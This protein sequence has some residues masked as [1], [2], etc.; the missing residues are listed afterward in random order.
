MQRRKVVIIGGGA[1]GFF[2]AINAAQ[3]NREL[4]VLILEKTHKVLSKVKVSGGGRCNVTH[5]LFEIPEMSRR[6]PRGLQFVKK[7]FHQFFTSDCIRWFEERGVRLKTEADGR[8]FPVTDS[9]QTIIDCF[10]QEVNRHG[11]QLRLNADVKTI[12]KTG[13]QFQLQLSNGEMLSADAVCIAC[14]GYPKAAAFEWLQQLGHTIEPPVPSLFTFNLP[15]HPI[16]DL[17]GVSVEQARVKIENSKLAEEGPVLITHWG[18]SGPA[19]LKL[20]A[21]GAQELAEKQYVFNVHINWIPAHTELSLKDAF[22]SARTQQASRK[23]ANTN[24][25]SLPNRLWLFLLDQSGI[26]PDLRFS[27][28]PAKSENQLIRNLIDYKVSVQGKTTFKEEFVT[29]GGIHLSE[30]DPNTLMSRKIQGLYFAGEIL[31]IDGITGG[32]NFQN[33][34]TTG[35]IAARNISLPLVK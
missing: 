28:L 4:E 26:G 21:W 16:T 13:D 5:A 27:E 8:M 18:L 22:R 30:V 24:L 9:S 14:G 25:G 23:V 35:W 33:A 6:Y 19:I 2:C 1:A 20:S 34:W 29:A 17:M 10:M 3:M 11:V 15:K 7:T 31:N 12:S 32:F